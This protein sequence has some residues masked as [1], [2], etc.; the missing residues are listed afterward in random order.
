[1]PKN[2]LSTL[3]PLNEGQNYTIQLID[4]LFSIGAVA[5]ILFAVFYGYGL[6]QI[7]N[8]ESFFSIENLHLTTIIC[9]IISLMFLISKWLL[10]Q[11]QINWAI[12]TVIFGMIFLAIVSTFVLNTSVYDPFNH[13]FYLS[14]VI[15]SVF[16]ERAALFTIATIGTLFNFAFFFLTLNGLIETAHKSLTLD[17][18]FVDSF[19]LILTATILVITVKQLLKNRV[20]LMRYKTSLEE[21][22][23]ERTAQFH[24]E[25]DRAEEANLAK[26]QF[27]ANMSHEL[28]TP[29]NA[30]IGYAELIDET[31]DDL[32]VKIV[33]KNISPDIEKIETAGRHLLELINNILDLSKIDAGKMELNFAYHALFP[34]VE[35]VCNAIHP[36]LHEKE[37][38]FVLDIVDF[39]FDEELIFVDKLKVE[40]ILINLLSNAIKFTKEGQIKFTVEELGSV[41]DLAVKFVVEDTGIGIEPEF[42]PQLFDR[43]NQEDN[44]STRKYDGTGL[45]LAICKQFSEMMGGEIS[46]TS[47]RGKGSKFTVIIPTRTV[48]AANPKYV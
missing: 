10:R 34:I 24:A 5:G 26:S 13:L 37:L 23:A 16:L 38:A 28:R 20:D 46:V 41:E 27:L 6:I 45:G 9:V 8:P 21:M 48:P 35:Q 40:Q 22:V 47:E 1:M 29:L 44:S 25:R 39:A 15:A 19:I 31:I 43:F 32:D 36:Q 2:E 18:V 12:S 7:D 30:I 42:L 17:D 11:N 33:R 3:Q 14:L 4:R